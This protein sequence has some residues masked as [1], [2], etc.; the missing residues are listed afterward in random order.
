V[1]SNNS[2]AD[3]YALAIGFPNPEEISTGAAIIEIIS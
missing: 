3:L 2:Q 1:A